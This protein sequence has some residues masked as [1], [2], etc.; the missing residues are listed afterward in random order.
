MLFVPG[1]T[2]EVLTLYCQC[3]LV[4]KAGLGLS[5]QTDLPGALALSHSVHPPGRHLQENYDGAAEIV[6]KQTPLHQQ[7]PS[8]VRILFLF[9]LCFPNDHRSLSRCHIIMILACR[10]VRSVTA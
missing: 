3:F 2:W 7:C 9:A 10:V 4:T 8:L 5:L 6:R 1:G